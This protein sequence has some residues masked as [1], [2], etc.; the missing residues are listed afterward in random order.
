MHY[1]SIHVSSLVEAAGRAGVDVRPLRA[2]AVAAGLW[3]EAPDN[4]RSIDAGKFE[5]LLGLCLAASDNPALGLLM[6]E[7][8]SLVSLGLS[9]APSASRVRSFRVVL[10]SFSAGY[11][12]S[13]DA[14]LPVLSVSSSCCSR[15]DPPASTCCSRADPPASTH[16]E[17]RAST[18]DEGEATLSFSVDGGDAAIARLRAEYAL[19]L[20]LLLMR[21]WAGPFAT[22]RFV[23]FP[24]EAPSYVGEY[25]RLFGGLARFGAE[26]ASICFGAKLLRAPAYSWGRQLVSPS[27]NR[28]RRLGGAHAGES[29][30]KFLL[31]HATSLFTRAGR[32]AVVTHPEMA[33]IAAQLGMT[34]RTLRRRLATENIRYRELWDDAR[35]ERALSL[36]LDLTHSPESLAE[37]LGFSEVSAFYRAFKRWTGFTPTHYRTMHQSDTGG[38]NE[39]RPSMLQTK[40]ADE[41][42]SRVDVRGY[43]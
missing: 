17:S 9:E 22:P 34:E 32:Q 31:A 4:H 18:E 33:T 13:I 20:C 11:A 19:T 12:A 8:A 27:S 41:Q 24:Y 38:A 23:S 15:A 29:V 25:E 30:R 35:R 36:A 16:A 37:T 26:S 1:T 40:D 7:Q 21:S 2:R 14:R 39:A 6:G 3:V 42:L 10:E 28:Y 43:A 5:E